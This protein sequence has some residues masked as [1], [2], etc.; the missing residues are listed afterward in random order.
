[1]FREM[2]RSGQ[3]MSKE[4]T[5]AILEKCS[6]GVLCLSGD[7]GYPY[8]VPLN[9]VF[10][11]GKIYFHCAVIGHKTDAIEKNNKAS[12]TVLETDVIAPPMCSSFYRSVIAFGTVSFIQDE[13]AQKEALVMMIDKYS[14]DK[15]GSLA[16]VDLML[17]RTSVFV[18][19]VE[20]V[21]G[22]ESSEFAAAHPRK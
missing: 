6:S 20:F 19:D 7:G 18:F 9:Y 11:D 2:R 10:A 21:T 4:K 8:G 13:A 16:E 17:P 22:K 5:E 3:Q 1:M 14:N 12:F 15:T